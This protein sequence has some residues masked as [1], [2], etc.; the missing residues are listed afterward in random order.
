MCIKGVC[1]RERGG[2]ERDRRSVLEEPE[3]A[4]DSLKLETIE[5]C[6]FFEPLCSKSC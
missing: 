5:L 6:M 1:V 4:L 2:R 3:V